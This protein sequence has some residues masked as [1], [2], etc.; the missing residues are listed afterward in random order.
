MP[1]FLVGQTGLNPGC[2]APWAPPPCWAVAHSCLLEARLCE[3][4]APPLG[5][6]GGHQGSTGSSRA[7]CVEAAVSTCLFSETPPRK[8]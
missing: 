1:S 3:V 8:K 4:G 2:R 6:V 5:A 7:D